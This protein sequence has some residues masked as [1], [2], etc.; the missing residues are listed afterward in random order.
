[1]M[2]HYLENR[3]GREREHRRNLQSRMFAGIFT[4]LSF[5]GMSIS[6][7]FWNEPYL[8]VSSVFFV[9]SLWVY[10]SIK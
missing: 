9:G 2:R 8:W 3:D 10:R 5:S 6:I 7:W 1:R 4:I